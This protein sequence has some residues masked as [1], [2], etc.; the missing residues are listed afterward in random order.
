MAKHWVMYPGM[1]KIL[2]MNNHAL[3]TQDW[4]T[5]QKSIRLMQPWMAVYDNIHYTRYMT[6]YW[7]TLNKLN[8]NGCTSWEVDYFQRRPF[9]S[10][11]WTN[12][13]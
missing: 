2:F 13:D 8:E 3:C 1:V 11:I 10:Y 5:F 4:D 7:S 6:V 9:S 12:M